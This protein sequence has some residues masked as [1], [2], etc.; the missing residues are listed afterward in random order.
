[1]N[2][3]TKK[4]NPPEKYIQIVTVDGHEFWF[5]GFVNYEKASNH[6]LDAVCQNAALLQ[7]A[8]P[9]VAQVQSQ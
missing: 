1:M 5:M 8:K 6:L 9:A 2:P 3:V 7:T 4:E